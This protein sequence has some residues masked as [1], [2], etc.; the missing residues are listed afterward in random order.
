M[1]PLESAGLFAERLLPDKWWRLAGATVLPAR[2]LSAGI[3]WS[4]ESLVTQEG[5]NVWTRKI[6]CFAAK[7]LVS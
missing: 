1:P 4:Q 3:L 5:V 7:A 6:A 2:V